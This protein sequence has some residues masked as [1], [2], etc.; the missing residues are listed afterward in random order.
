M[1]LL[2]ALCCCSSIVLAAAKAQPSMTDL[3]PKSGEVLVPKSAATEK[4]EF[5]GAADLSKTTAKSASCKDGMG[6]WLPG[7]AGFDR[8]V[9]ANSGKASAGNYGNVPR[10]AL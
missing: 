7:T 3:M 9:E 8:C 1:K 6:E 5:K 10:Q 4:N 2:F